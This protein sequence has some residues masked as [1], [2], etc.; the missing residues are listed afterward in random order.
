MVYYLLTSCLYIIQFHSGNLYIPSS[1]ELAFNWQGS[2]P[3]GSTDPHL[4][5][6]LHAPAHQT[7]HLPV[8]SFYFLPLI[9][10]FHLLY[11]P[12]PHFSII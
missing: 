7:T 9:F 11:Q 3:P 1:S 4:L 10:T 12:C 5:E 8:F 6:A 2:P